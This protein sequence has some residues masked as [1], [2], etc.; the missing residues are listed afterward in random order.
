MLVKKMS[1]VQVQL[2]IKQTILKQ[3]F[4]EKKNSLFE[5]FFTMIDERIKKTKKNG[6]IIAFWQRKFVEKIKRKHATD[7]GRVVFNVSTVR[8]I[9]V[10]SLSSRRRAQREDGNDERLVRTVR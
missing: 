8:S 6:T 3:I 9:C 4:S 1:W 2:V 7:D 5:I 10:S